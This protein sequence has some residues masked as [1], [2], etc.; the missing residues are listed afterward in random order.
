V[1]NG[2]RRYGV[3]LYNACDGDRQLFPVQADTHQNS[4]NND[5]ALFPTAKYSL[6]PIIAAGHVPAGLAPGRAC[7]AESIA[8]ASLHA[9]LAPDSYDATRPTLLTVTT[10]FASDFL[11]RLREGTCTDVLD[12]QDLGWTLRWPDGAI[13]TLGGSG[14]SGIAASHTLP[15]VVSGGTRTSD[16]T[17]IA[18]LHISGQAMDFDADG[19]LVTVHRDA[20]VDISNHQGANGLGAAPVYVPPQLAVAG[21][22]AAQLGD[23][24]VGSPDPQPARHLTTIRGRLLNIYPDVVAIRPGTE[25]IDG[26][27][28]GTS[29]SVAAAWTYLGGVTDAPPPDATSPGATGTATTAVGV[30]WNHAERLDGRGQPIDEAVPLRIQVI[31]TYPDGHVESTTVSGDLPVSIY[32]PALSDSG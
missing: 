23:G 17:A 12:W 5:D 19:N 1:V 30:Q 26:V 10:S 31:T 9:T 24:S 27:V 7:N 28:V 2:N 13:D 21:R 18:H 32:Y 8:S 20:Y 14:H 6:C 11:G 22:A 29:H 15:P 16:V 25:S 3:F 4:C